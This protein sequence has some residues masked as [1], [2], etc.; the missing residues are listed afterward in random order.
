MIRPSGIRLGSEMICK[1]CKGRCKK[2]GF[3]MQGM[4][5]QATTEI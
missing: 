3:Q 1:F 2:D 5:P 4:S